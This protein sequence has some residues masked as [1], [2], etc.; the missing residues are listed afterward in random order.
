MKKDDMIINIPLECTFY[1]RFRTMRIVAKKNQFE[2]N[3]QVP[4]GVIMIIG[5][6]PLM[7]T[8]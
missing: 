8:I 5:A 6:Y 2:K 3:V 4:T 1:T 7:I